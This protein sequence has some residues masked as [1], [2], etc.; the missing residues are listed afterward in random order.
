MNK[1]EKEDLDKL[2][3][4]IDDAWI[5]L[6]LDSWSEGKVAKLIGLNI[7]L[8]KIRGLGPSYGKM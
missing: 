5:E 8:D 6:N 1:N 2:Y 4:Q 3:D 7:K